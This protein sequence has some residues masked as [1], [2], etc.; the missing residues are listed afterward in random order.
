MVDLPTATD[1]ATP[2][3]NG[4]ALGLLA[5]ERGGGRVQL[6]CGFDVQVQEPGQRK[7]DL[8]DLL[9]VQ[10]IAEA[11]QA[12][13]VL[14]IK[15]LLH[16]GCEPGP[17]LPVQL[18][19]RGDTLAVRFVALQSHFRDSA[20]HAAESEM[21]RPARGVQECSTGRLAD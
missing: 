2:M 9:H 11:T 1:P 7:V 19:E 8:A 15:G 13:N 18:H 5:Q 12:D 21:D 4:R 14:F 16:L 6:A 3:T 10:G 17:G 20:P